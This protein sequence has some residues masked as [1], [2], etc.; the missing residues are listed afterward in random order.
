MMLK[1]ASNS[2]V[3]LMN[4]DAVARCMAPLLLRPI[5]SGDV[6]IF[7]DN[8]P[9]AASNGEEHAMLQAMNAANV[10]G[11][12]IRAMMKEFDQIFM[13]RKRG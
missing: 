9:S 5:F 10:G 7:V 13:V 2:A 1:V 6:P 11:A 4:A 12:L 8:G 3:N